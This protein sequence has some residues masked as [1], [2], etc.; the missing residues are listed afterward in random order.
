MVFH[1][2]RMQTLCLEIMNKNWMVEDNI[3]KS[4]E[5]RRRKESEKLISEIPMR[6]GASSTISFNS[7]KYV[8]TA[9]RKIFNQ[10]ELDKMRSSEHP[11]IR[12]IDK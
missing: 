2:F 3:G 12:R 10:E 11:K 4:E 7:K 6:I 8:G 9:A 1:S 5:Y